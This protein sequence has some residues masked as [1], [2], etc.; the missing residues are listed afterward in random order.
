MKVK[1]DILDEIELRSEGVQDIL[2]RP[3]HWM[4]R[5]GNTLIFIILLLI[6]FM[7]YIIKYPEFVPSQVIISSINPPEKL[8]SRINSKIETLFVKDHQKVTKGQPLLIL[9]ST[10]QYQDVLKLRDIVNSMESRQLQN[11]PLAET[12][13]F[14]LGEVQGDYNAFAKALT[15]EQLYTRLQPYAPD[16]IAAEQSL[17]ESRNRIQ[18]LQQQKR[19]EQAKYELSKKEFDRSQQLYGQGVIS[20]SELDQ[21]RIKLLQAGQSVENINLSISQLQEGVSGIQKTKSGVSINAQKDKV[22]FSSQTIQLFEQLRK[23]L[24]S[25]EQNYLFASS[26]DGS[27]SFQQY[28]GEHQFVKAGEVLITVMPDKPEALIGRLTV[29]S[30]NSGKIMEGQKV[31][32]KLDNYPFQEFGIVEGR[33]RNMSSVPDKDG[34]YYVDVNIPKGLTTSFNKKL[35]FNKELKGNAEIVTKD[36]RLIERFF[37]QFRKLLG[38]QS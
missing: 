24:N 33:V 34:N 19:L 6:L 27:V 18:A 29:P 26:T 14:K 8:E 22:N 25:W 30:T 4:I 28:L 10:A 3:P 20:A 12:S 1:T 5:W 15:D 9:Q 2:T 21:E 38:Y 35:I 23:S 37:Y 17:S 32:I 31:L 16:N 13:G 7:S 11:F 36:L